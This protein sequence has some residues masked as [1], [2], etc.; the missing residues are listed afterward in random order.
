MFLLGL[1]APTSYI[2]IAASLTIN[3]TLR[4]LSNAILNSHLTLVIGFMPN[5]PRADSQQQ[6]LSRA[7]YEQ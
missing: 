6:V 5:K 1:W 3:T 2:A 4:I 7:C